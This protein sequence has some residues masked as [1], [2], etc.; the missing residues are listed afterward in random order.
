MFCVVVVIPVLGSIWIIN[1]FVNSIKTFYFSVSINNCNE[2]YLLDNVFKYLKVV[3]NLEVIDL[4]LWKCRLQMFLLQVYKHLLPTNCPQPNSVRIIFDFILKHSIFKFMDTYIQQ[5]LGTSI[6]TRMASPYANLFM[7]KEER[8]IILT[9]LH[10]I[11][12]C[13]RNIH[14]YNQFHY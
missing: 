12:F 1:G 3:I 11:C 8:N 5:I 14:E 6:R 9:F 10:L 13:K 4:L 7:E 2:K